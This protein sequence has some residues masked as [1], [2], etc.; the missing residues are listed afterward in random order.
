MINYVLNGKAK[1]LLTAGLKKKTIWMSE[2]FPEPI[3][4]EETVKVELDLPGYAKKNRF[5][6][7]NSF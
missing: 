7:C 4:F 1:I 3:S 2:Y 5:K 6:K